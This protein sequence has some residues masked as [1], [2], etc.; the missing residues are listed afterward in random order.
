MSKLLPIGLLIAAALMRSAFPSADPPAT[1]SWSGGYFSDEGFWTHNARNR[2]V[3]GAAIQDEWNNMYMSP[4][5]HAVTYLVFRIWGVG[6]VQARIQAIS[7][8]LGALV[9]LTLIAK[10]RLTKPLWLYVIIF[11]G[12]NYLSLVYNRLALLENPIILCLLVAWY[13]LLRSCESAENPRTRWAILA[14]ISA[15]AAYLTKTT[16]VFFLAVLLLE[17]LRALLYRRERNRWFQ[18]MG[19]AGGFL[20]C[21]SPYYWFIYRPHHELLAQYNTYYYSQQTWNPAVLMRNVIEQP[22]LL[23]FVRTPFLLFLAIAGLLA[24]FTKMRTRQ[25]LTTLELTAAGWFLSYAGFMAIFGYR[26]LR[27]YIP[28][29]P[30]L[31]LMAAQGLS[32][33]QD[34]IASARRDALTRWV[35]ILLTLVTSAQA[36]LLIIV[37]YSPVPVPG[38]TGNPALPRLG[39]ALF[40]G[41]VGS[42]W[43]AYRSEQVVRLLPKLCLAGFLMLNLGEYAHWVATRRYDVEHARQYLQT[44]LAP[45]IIAGQWAPQLCLGTAHKAIP[46]W[47]NYVNDRDPFTRYEIR[48]ILS[49]NYHLGDEYAHQFSWFPNEMAKTRVIT[50]FLIKDSPV[51]LSEFPRQ[52]GSGEGIVY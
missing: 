33:I 8:S 13:C 16:S 26:P 34:V 23:Y 17:P 32:K 43:L 39:A 29:L 36:A 12:F 22:F 14:G 5:V 21:I 52:M 4:L 25:S 15:G 31:V 1:V 27:Y 19:I 45:T 20:A 6:I 51:I 42:A 46:L 35:V 30:A 47:K 9:L 41:L 11:A 2:I 18:I 3:F 28:I 50:T 48:Y 24:L 40:L 7:Y 10:S 38:L 44:Q 49:W 37:P